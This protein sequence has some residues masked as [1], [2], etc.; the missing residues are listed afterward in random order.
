M[1]A[2]GDYFSYQQAV[3]NVDLPDLH[4]P[5]DLAAAALHIPQRELEIGQPIDRRAGLLEL[6]LIGESGAHRIACQRRART[7]QADDHDKR[8]VR[9]FRM[10]LY[11]PGWE[12]KHLGQA[13]TP[14]N[15]TPISDLETRTASSHQC[16]MRDL[17][18]L[19]K[20]GLGQPVIGRHA[21]TSVPVPAR[22]G[23]Q[24]EQREEPTGSGWL[25]T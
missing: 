23:H 8:N 11:S 3:D 15:T 19:G 21:F 24:T 18:N 4:C 6:T 7:Q 12:V 25:P 5:A 10:H 16:T 20:T 14:G 13:M 1:G 17:E 9:V 2:L 22:R